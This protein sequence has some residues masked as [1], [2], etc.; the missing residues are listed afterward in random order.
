[1]KEFEVEFLYNDID[2]NMYTHGEATVTMKVKAD[3]YTTAYFVSQR[4]QR[5]LGADVFSINE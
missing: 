3:D 1:M 5:V 4:L 2:D